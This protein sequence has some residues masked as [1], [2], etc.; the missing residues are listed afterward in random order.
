M[1]KP[2]FWVQQRRKIQRNKTT[3]VKTVFK[4]YLNTNAWQ[5]LHN[6]ECDDDTWITFQNDD[7]ISCSLQ[8]DVTIIFNTPSVRESKL[9]RCLMERP[10]WLLTLG[11][12]LSSIVSASGGGGELFVR[13]HKAVGLCGMISDLKESQT[14]PVTWESRSW[15]KRWSNAATL[16]CLHCKGGNA[17]RWVSPMPSR[18]ACRPAC[19]WTPRSP[20][21][22]GS[23]PTRWPLHQQTDTKQKRNVRFHTENETFTNR[24]SRWS[25]V[26]PSE[27]FLLLEDL[28]FHGV[29]SHRN[30]KWKVFFYFSN[31]TL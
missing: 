12:S 9:I 28:W 27:C 22:R 16:T 10:R 19:D 8:D 13:P 6:G 29:R 7:V 11:Q 3:R 20:S 21:G 30:H 31:K 26:F 15:M 24:T 1:R 5:T 18:G 17:D 14:A 23:C 4:K 25:R 2:N